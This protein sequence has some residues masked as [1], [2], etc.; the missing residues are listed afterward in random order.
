MNHTPGPWS[1]LSP[2]TLVGNHGHRPV[3]LTAR[4]LDER[5]KDGRLVEFD[6]KGPN[7]RLIAAAPELLEALKALLPIFDLDDPR[8]IKDF[9]AECGQAE[10]AIAK[11]EGTVKV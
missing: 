4:E 2:E 11:A 3:I 9:M 6:P 8:E 1:W 10:A 7:A 5:G